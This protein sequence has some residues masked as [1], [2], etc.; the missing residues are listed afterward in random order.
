MNYQ[1]MDEQNQ[2]IANQEIN[3]RLSGL[4][5]ILRGLAVSISKYLIAANSGG[6]LAILAY[7]NSLKNVDPTS[8]I[9]V[10]LVF[11][12]IGLVLIS[13]VLFWVCW[14]VWKIDSQY[15]KDMSVFY[16]NQISF[17]ELRRRDNERTESD[18]VEYFLGALSFISFMVA[19]ISGAINFV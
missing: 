15:K 16:N 14:R 9:K 18:K 2:A 5:D 8:S 10:S 17:F 1:E 12:V 11:F 3:A 6:I 7:L 19:V 13:V 4:K